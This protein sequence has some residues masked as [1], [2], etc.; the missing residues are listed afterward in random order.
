M[1]LVSRPHGQMPQKLPARQ[2]LKKE[3]LR[4]SPGHIHGALETMWGVEH[5]AAPQQ[6]FA[7][8]RESMRRDQACPAK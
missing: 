7:Q 1:V 6:V 3:G 5:G 2:I 8:Q 4:D